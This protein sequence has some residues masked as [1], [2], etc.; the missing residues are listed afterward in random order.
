M[1][2]RLFHTLA[3]TIS[4]SL[5]AMQAPSWAA[6]MW[7]W[8][9]KQKELRRE[10]KEIVRS[11]STVQETETKRL[12]KQHNDALEVYKYCL[13]LTMQE[14]IVFNEKIESIKR[15]NSLLKSTQVSIAD[16]AT[17]HPTIALVRRKLK[18]RNLNPDAV[19]IELSD[20]YTAYQEL[21]ENGTT[22]NA[23]SVET[24][25]S[26]PDDEECAIDHEITHLQEHHMLETSILLDILL[27]R[28]DDPY[29]EQFIQKQNEC[30]AVFNNVKYTTE[31]EA[32]TLYP[33]QNYDAAK[34][35][36][37]QWKH[38]VECRFLPDYKHEIRDLDHFD[39]HPVIDLKLWDAIQTLKKNRN[40]NA[41]LLIMIAFNN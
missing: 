22:R 17:L 40:G 26:N 8:S 1:K 5:S 6:N 28:K 16:E 21:L 24:N 31:Y 14:R 13:G 29:K 2:L 10:V 30:K 12:K 41:I 9:Q 35:A 34:K 39:L 37:N 36:R 32:D 25:N 4:P 38:Q 20:E 11:G 3:L 27:Q 15:N 23:I 33:L 7:Q 18:E 19:E